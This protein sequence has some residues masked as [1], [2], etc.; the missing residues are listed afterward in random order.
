MKLNLSVLL[1]VEV[2]GSLF[3]LFSIAKNFSK[4]KKKE[5][6]N[7]CCVSSIGKIAKI[8]EVDL[9]C[10]KQKEVSAFKLYKIGYKKPRL[11]DNVDYRNLKILIARIEEK[12]LTA[13]ERAS[14]NVCKSTLFCNL[15]QPSTINREEFSDALTVIIKLYAKYCGKDLFSI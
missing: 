2:L 12:S 11:D 3:L 10:D 9:S 15:R 6:L 13:I 5:I 1:I 8:E 14:F 7:D 4:I